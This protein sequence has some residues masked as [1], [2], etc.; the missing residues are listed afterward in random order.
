MS[1][2][3]NAGKQSG[4]LTLLACGSPGRRLKGLAGRHRLHPRAGICLWPCRAIHTVGMR[5]A[6]D[7]VFLNAAGRVIKRVSALPPNRWA[8]CWRA[9]RVVEVAAGT[10]AGG[11]ATDLRV[12]QAVARLRRR[13]CGD[14]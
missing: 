10:R 5:I 11:G 1:A 7:V 3:A 12:E 2:H 8:G 14:T 6:I 9:R 13:Q 4:R